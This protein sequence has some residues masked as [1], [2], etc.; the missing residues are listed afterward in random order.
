MPN[1]CFNVVN[2]TRILLVGF[3]I[4]FAASTSAL[5]AEK[6]VFEAENAALTIS[7]VGDNV[8][9]NIDWIVVGQGDLGLPPDI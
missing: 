6:H 1:V 8:A 9:V 7:R 5:A 2:D 3:L 4:F